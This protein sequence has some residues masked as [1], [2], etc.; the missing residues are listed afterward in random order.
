MTPNPIRRRTSLPASAVEENG[1][2]LT[3]AYLDQ[4]TAIVELIEQLPDRPERIDD[5]L[6]WQFVSYQ[7]YFHAAAM[8]GRVSA[9]DVYAALNRAMRANVEDTV[10]DLDRKALGAVAAIR[11]HYKTYGEAR[12]D[13][14]S[15][16][17]VRASRHLREG[18]NRAQDLMRQVPGSAANFT[19]RRKLRISGA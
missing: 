9:T 16:I 19:Q 14:M 4:F 1:G 13:L 8:P 3:A 5:L 18:L 7:D 12:P 17:C 11:R 6:N 15:E 2:S 10:D